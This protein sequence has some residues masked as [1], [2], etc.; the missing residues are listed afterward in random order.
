MNPL[1]HYENTS[2]PDV[3]ATARRMV[4]AAKKAGQKLPFSAALRNAQKVADDEIWMNDLV[5]INVDRVHFAPWVHLSHKRR[6]SKEPVRL[7]R[8]G[9]Q[10]KDQ[11]VGRE[12]EGLELYPRESRLVD[13]SNQFHLWIAPGGFQIPLGDGLDPDRVDVWKFEDS[14]FDPAAKPDETTVDGS[15]RIEVREFTVDTLKPGSPDPTEFCQIIVAQGAEP[16]DDWRF[17]QAVKNEFV[18]EDC[19]AIEL[20]PARARVDFRLT[21]SVLWACRDPEIS[22]PIGYDSGR[23]VVDGD[24]FRKDGSRQRSLAPYEIRKEDST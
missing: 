9:L 21:A 16:I 12:A 4:R 13:T 22:F 17:L 6:G 3:R 20:Y 10:M 23:M 5:Q 2:V 18:G 7:W 14:T 1:E 11:I 24:G 19:E 15:L 8:E